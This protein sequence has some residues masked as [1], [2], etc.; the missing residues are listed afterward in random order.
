MLP[1]PASY[2]L[3]RWLA[4]SVLV[5]AA[6]ALAAG[7][8]ATFKSISVSTDGQMTLVRT[9]QR[10]VG[11]L[12]R[13]LDTPVAPSDIVVPPAASILE[14]G[15]TVTVLRA[16]RVRIVADGRDAELLTHAGTV[17][18]VLTESGI[19]LAPA[20]LLTVNGRP[21]RPVA[22]LRGD[23]A[24]AAASGLIMSPERAW[25]G[26][27]SYRGEGKLE[28]RDAPLEIA[29][30]RAVPLVLTEGA[31]E[32]TLLTTADTVGE[33]LRG[34]GIPVYAGDLVQPALASPVSPGIRVYVDRA[35]PV[36]IIADGKTYRT[37]TQAQTVEEALAEEGVRLADKD[38]S[39]PEPIASVTSGMTMRV[40][41]V[42]EEIVT[43]DEYLPY[44]TI[45]QPSPDLELDERMVAQTGLE[46]VFK[47]RIHVVYEN[48][49]ETKR[50]LEKEWID[51]E[52]VT[53]I[54]AYGTKVVVREAQTADGP[55]QYW[56]RLRV[57][58]TWYNAS[59]GWFPRSSPYYGM[60]RTGLWATK[61]I[62][63]VDPSVIRLHTNMYVPGYGFGA[64]EDTGGAIKGMRIDLA[65]DEGD[66]NS[67]APGWVTI[68]LLAPA[69]P[70]SQITYI[71]PDYP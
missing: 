22:G 60:T 43:E 4:A 49:V 30:R 71:L 27:A 46:G 62:I 66:P 44:N 51:R 20:D 24:T 28:A 64:A 25:A 68:Y 6:L 61:G 55:I 67:S 10:T 26:T 31:A 23:S 34:S 65:F 35:S 58:A 17:E 2:R 14:D 45:W 15:D 41:R 21:A 3:P 19:S 38:Y 37:R 13:E 8:A 70:A 39:E 9:H 59:H 18:Q 57:L 63:A 33:A 36:T 12:L 52:P 5:A 16:S 54:I 1:V 56:R 48:G 40:T 50:L 32:S 7:Y 42:R 53:K 47:R 29:V 69:P 11:S